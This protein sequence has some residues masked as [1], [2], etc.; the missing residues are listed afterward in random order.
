MF[1]ATYKTSPRKKDPM[2]MKSFALK[3]QNIFIAILI[4]L[5][6]GALLNLGYWQQANCAPAY[7]IEG[8][9]L[10]ATPEDTGVTVE[11]DPLLEE[12]Y[13]EVET[14]GVLLFFVK[15]GETL[16]LSRIV[17]EEAIKSNNVND[18]LGKLKARYG[19]PDK[20]QI[21][22]SGMRPKN[23]ENYTTTVKNK[24]IWN[25]SETQEFIAE[26]ESR[27]VVYELLDHSPENIKPPE[28]TE[29]PEDERLGTEGWNPDY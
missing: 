17:Q 7:H 3:A 21:K 4:L 19:I 26:I 6:C 20:Q 12:K 29:A 22:T 18:V 27:R 25:I 28:K 9:Y 2:H 13:Y 14:N 8:F 11:I 1:L 10:G 5:F 15:V 24:A 16:R 23:R